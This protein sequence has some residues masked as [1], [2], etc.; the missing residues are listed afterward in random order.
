MAT[1]KVHT[2][3]DAAKLAYRALRAAVEA[4]APAELVEQL[5]QAWMAADRAD[6]RRW[7][8][9]AQIER[10][11]PET[12]VIEPVPGPAVTRMQIIRGE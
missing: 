8:V 10:A 11:A 2:L 7:E 4:D 3:G 9:R 12:P 5:R 1:R 6:Q